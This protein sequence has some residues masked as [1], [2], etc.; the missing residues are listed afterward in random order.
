M[1]NTLKPIIFLAFA[2][3][4]D[5]KSRYLRNLAKE[6][7]GI[8]KSLRHLLKSGTCE[9]IERYNVTVEEIFEVFQD[10]GDRIVI[11]HFGGHADYYSLLFQNEQGGTKMVNGI[12]LMNFLSYYRNTLKLVFING[13]TTEWVR[14]LREKGIP[15]VIGTNN[16]VNDEVATNI[17]IQFYDNLASGLTIENAFRQAERF[18]F[19]KYEE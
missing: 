16:N 7:R 9:L 13:S 17:A 19:A 5:D 14:E 18:I 11:F 6:A 3:D 8:R 4:L 2:N 1:K 15:A 10:F 12:A